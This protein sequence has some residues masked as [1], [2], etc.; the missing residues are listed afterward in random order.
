[1]KRWILRILVGAAVLVLLFLVAVQIILWTNL[2]R[3]W[4]L[5]AIQQKLQLRIE[6][7]EFSTGWSGQ[8]SLEGVRASLP[9]SHESFLEAQSLKVEHTSLLALIVGRPLT[10]TAVTID[11]PNLLVRQGADRRWNVA[12]VAELVRRAGGGKQP[13][14]LAAEGKPQPSGIPTLPAI[15]VN[16]ATVRIVDLSGGQATI[17]SLA[18]KGDPDGPLVWRYDVSIPNHVTLTGELAP[19][20]EWQHQVDVKLAK[21]GTLLRPLVADPAALDTLVLDGRW[22]GRAA[23]GLTG[24][25]DLRNFHAA[26]Y[27][28]TGALNVT[29]GGENDAFATI[30]PAGLVVTPPKDAG[31]N[32]PFPPAR[33]NAG[34]ITLARGAA[35]VTGLQLAFAGGEVRASGSYSLIAGAGKIETTWNQLVFP[36]GTTHSGT[37]TASVRQPWPG[38]PLIDVTLTST[39][40]RGEDSWSTSLR[41]DGA[42]RSWQDIDWTLKAPKL[43][44]A[45]VEGEQKQTFDLS[46]LT[47]ALSTRGD[48]VTLDSLDLPAGSLYGPFQ[49]G[50]LRGTGQYA[51]KTGQWFA[52]VTGDNWPAPGAAPAKPAD[53]AFASAGVVA[54]PASDAKKP[55]V[56]DWQLDAYGDARTARATLKQ[57]FMKAGGYQVWARGGVH[58]GEKGVPAQLHVFAWYPPLDYTFHEVD[59]DPERDVRVAGRLQSELHL[60]KHLHPLDLDI[61]GVLYTRD[62]SV[63]GH[64]LGDVAV[65]VSG[66]A[67]ENR[68]QLGST[69]LEL[70]AGTWTLDTTYSFA[71]KALT[72]VA[73]LKHLSLA[74][75]D[76]FVAP[77]PN[78]RGSMNGQW[79]IY[80]PEFDPDRMTV[81]GTYRVDKLGHYT[82]P[83]TTR[84]ATVVTEN[85]LQGPG[86]PPASTVAITNAN[87]VT[88]EDVKP[89]GPDRAVPASFVATASSADVR[90][91]P[92]PA[93]TPDVPLTTTPEPATKPAAADKLPPDEEG[94]QL[95]PIA[96]SV[97]GRVT[98]E[99][100]VLRFHDI[101]ARYKG[102]R[103]DVEGI[104]DAELS[105][106]IRDP[107]RL[108]LQAAVASWPLYVK[109]NETRQTT[110]ALVWAQSEVSID[111]KNLS[112][113]GPVSVQ[114]T[115]ALKDQTVGTIRA[116][117][118]LAKRRIDLKTLTGDVLGGP[119][120]GEGYYYLDSPF[121]SRGRIAFD[122]INATRLTQLYPIAEGLRGVFSGAITFSPSDPKTRPAGPFAA[123]GEIKV[124]DGG[125]RDLSFGDLSFLAYLDT[126]R[127][128]LDKLNW[129]VAGGQLNGWT[130]L[131]WYKS[132]P[133][134][135][136]HV[137][138]G[139]DKLDID[140]I[141]KAA[142]KPG[143]AHEPMPGR[144]SGTIVAAGN[145][146]TDAGR[147]TASGDVQLRVA[148]SDLV[149]IDAVTALY[150]LLSLQGGNKAPAG[151]GYVI[152]RLE[153][154][155]LEIARSKYFNRGVDLYAAVTAV[156]V[157]KGVDSPLTG[158]AGGSARP[159]KDLKLPF[160]GDVDKLLSALQGNVATVNIGGTIADPKIKAV[161]FAESGGAF[162]RFLV[163]EVQ[164][165]VGGTAGQ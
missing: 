77:P 114:A 107:R 14:S 13:E 53:A 121:Q 57:F 84:P 148:D 155:R 43:N 151:K 67:D 11:R 15:R 143:Q 58:Y 111:L 5:A 85:A 145:P 92:K 54:P 101:R 81:A 97:E 9:L 134:P 124:Q 36:A 119:I 161:P 20:G 141:V 126:N 47:V 131:T 73:S 12:E 129:H 21:L 106:P 51:L 39:G 78:L 162:R 56:A 35:T 154:P 27:T 100:G 62:F 95:L 133:T 86:A 22:N 59:K 96:D 140:Q 150:N 139:L 83:P 104:A 3:N 123:R 144:L 46:N 30:T 23:D 118:E 136:I 1:M 68:V 25:L 165:E 74:N 17:K 128:V 90:A 66:K 125:L 80:L 65:Q 24:R 7:D 88:P 8:T 61:K 108:Q 37:M 157:F 63:K 112:A 38:Q 109:D 113:T 105:F 55:A 120:S 153:G 45:Q 6:A 89:A 160:M 33:A 42:G 99:K 102:D 115:F 44:Y 10:V 135:F 93:P 50:T 69:R 117:A 158:T 60:T 28:A 137:N 130:R 138:L 82:P 87:R 31:G 32:A 18:I 40:T 132:D 149:N 52:Y 49:R 164:N 70:L 72:L 16:D 110:S 91:A 146:F 142:R 98:G 159:F 34:A 75:V 71:D 147:R 156:D 64:P 41:L 19:G 103:T 29:T 152:A 76:R 127:A 163:G 116:A 48:L 79:K 122:N 2:P 4:V 94:G 26:G